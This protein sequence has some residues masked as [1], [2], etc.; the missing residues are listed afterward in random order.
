MIQMLET[1]PSAEMPPFNNV[2]NEIFDMV[3][4]ADTMR[5]TLKDLINWFVREA[6]LFTRAKSFVC[7]AQ[8][9]L[10][11][12]ILIDIGSFWAYEVND[13]RWKLICRE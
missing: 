13:P 12:S 6:S 8:G 5:I 10:V 11:L 9:G 7:S 2:Q 4:P 1:R 3:K